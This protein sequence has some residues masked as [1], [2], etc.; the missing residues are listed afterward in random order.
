MSE[1]DVKP[2]VA[3]DDELQYTEPVFTEVQD[4]VE[5]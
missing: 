4:E 1:D 3:T 5:E 2:I